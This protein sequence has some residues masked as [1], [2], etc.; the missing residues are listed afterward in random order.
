MQISGDASSGYEGLKLQ[1]RAG[2]ADSVTDAALRFDDLCGM[3]QNQSHMGIQ[4]TLAG[5]LALQSWMQPVDS[6]SM[7]HRYL[8]C[9]EDNDPN[10]QDS[11]NW[12]LLMEGTVTNAQEHDSERS[13]SCRTIEWNILDSRSPFRWAS[14]D[15]SDS[16]S[17]PPDGTW[18]RLR[19]TE[20]EESSDNLLVT[21]VHQT[22]DHIATGSRFQIWYEPPPMSGRNE[23]AWYLLSDAPVPGIASDLRIDRQAFAGLDNLPVNR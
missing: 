2:N 15:S 13:T 11:G 21:F 16:S 8:I 3:F 7:T 6:G 19:L 12:E 5:H 17:T 9:S 23:I 22:A 20:G 1:P 4:H 18:W 10:R 14:A